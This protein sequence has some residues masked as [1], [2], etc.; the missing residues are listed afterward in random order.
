MKHMCVASWLHTTYGDGKVMHAHM[1]K[2]QQSPRKTCCAV[3]CCG[4][5]QAV[6]GGYPKFPELET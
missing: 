1:T 5:L 2:Q 3:A 6:G 4:M